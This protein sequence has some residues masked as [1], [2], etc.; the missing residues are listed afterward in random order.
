MLLEHCTRHPK[1]LP[2][3]KHQL[4]SLETLC[5]ELFENDLALGHIS[6]K[7]LVTGQ[8]AL[9]GENPLEASGEVMCCSF[10]LICDSIA[11]R[12]CTNFNL[13]GSTSHVA[14]LQLRY[15]RLV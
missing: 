4:A 14:V 9:I 7:A 12:R 15:H 2:V 5:T 1:F 13:G 6:L 8:L 3:L 10:L 11:G